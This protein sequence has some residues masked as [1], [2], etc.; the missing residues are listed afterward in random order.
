MFRR[1]VIKIVLGDWLF[2]E[3]IYGYFLHKS[4]EFLKCF[5]L[6][7]IRVFK[8]WVEHDTG[9]SGARGDELI[10]RKVF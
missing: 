5:E 2:L 1:R 6:V 8:S 4:V 10:H 3:Y 7:L 9:F